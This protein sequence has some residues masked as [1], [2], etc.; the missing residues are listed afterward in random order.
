MEKQTTF[1]QFADRV[2]DLLSAD[3]VVVGLAAGGSWIGGQLDEYS[4]IDFVLV[5][6]E[7]IGGNKEMMMGYAERFGHLLNAFTGEHLGE[8]RLLI[9]LYDAPLLHVD[10]K[11]VTLEEFGQRVEDPVL[12]LDKGGRLQEV[13]EQT[14]AHFPHPAY[15]WIEDRFWI[16]IHYTLLKVGRGEYFEALESLGYMR[17][18]VLGPLMHIKN[19]NEPRRLRRVETLCRAE[20]IAGLQATLAGYDREEIYAA[21]RQVVKLYRQLREEIYGAEVELRRAS[22]ER[23]IAYFDS[24]D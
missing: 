12:L 7:A 1:Q 24:I 16:W 18:V 2:V 10:I 21:L 3:D 23:V 11:F 9:C 14:T 17:N 5:T 22:E 6:R 8:P 20:E 15:Q 13:L 4:D 19:G